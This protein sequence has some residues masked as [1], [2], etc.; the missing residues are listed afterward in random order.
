MVFL[1]GQYNDNKVFPYV[2]VCNP[3]TSYLY[4]LEICR[5][6]LWLKNNESAPFIDT[7]ST[8]T[9]KYLFS[10]LVQGWEI[11]IARVARNDFHLLVST[12]RGAPAGRNEVVFQSSEIRGR[13]IRENEIPYHEAGRT[14]L[15]LTL[16]KDQAHGRFFGCFLDKSTSAHT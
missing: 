5:Y 2:A 11:N 10:C 6:N 16:C 13:D 9:L 3:H 4:E 14:H 7:S 12:D 1:G 8:K 15:D